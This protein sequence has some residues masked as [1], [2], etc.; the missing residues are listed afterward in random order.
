MP[1]VI[2]LLGAPRVERDD[3]EM[4]T[5]RGHKAWGLL[6]YLLLADAPV[7]RSTLCSLLFAD[8]DDPLAALRWNLSALR[9]LL[10]DASSFRGDPLTVR[11]RA[12]DTA[13]ACEVLRGSWRAL[14]ALGGFEHDLL[15]G[16]S[17]SSAPSFEIWLE[18]ERRRLRG[19]AEAQLHEAA[20][21]HLG[22]GDA[23]RAADLASRLVRLNPYDENYQALLV[24]ALSSAG[25]GVAAARQV[26]ACRDLFRRELGVEPGPALAA[27]AATPTAQPVRPAT[28]GRAGVI[29]QVEAGVAAI[30]AGAV[31]PGLHCL[32]LA[33]A[34]AE[35]LADRQLHVRALAALGTA[36][37]HA[38][39]GWDEEGATVLHRALAVAGAHVPELTAEVS[40]EL[41][42]VEFLRARYDRVEPWLARAEAEAGQDANL[43][44]RVLTVRGS[45]LTDVGRYGAA[46]EALHAALELLSD[47]RHRSYALSM[48]GRLHLLRRELDQAGEALD[49]SLELAGRRGWTAFVPWPESM[50]A[51]VDME[52]GDLEVAADRLDHAFA[53]SCHVGDPCWEGMA[54][55]GLGLLQWT[56]GEVEGALVTLR[57]ARARCTRL[58]DGYLWLDAYT[59][60][61]MCAIAV[62]HGLEEGRAWARELGA[63]AA[64]TGMRELAA[65]SFLH[66]AALGEPELLAAAA[67]LVKELDSPRLTQALMRADAQLVGPAAPV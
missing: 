26:A 5:P 59:L 18:T 62:D 67:V 9:K 42:F 48:L 8:A 54:G 12:G 7:P 29:A 15:A 14:E 45:A 64:R 35:E 37:V 66:R 63:I 23:G 43:R 53:L 2:H 24:R 36:L 55:R 51:A 56:R 17:F 57:D 50:R 40:R 44:G 47:D 33:V 13:D 16:M 11:L 19:A 60:E 52:R 46:R 4:P 30:G 38:V 25:E 20:R 27:A 28:R 61:A 39:R 65:W 6:A 31:E 22:A 49:R 58:P 41:G 34:E 3:R 1:L 32:R 21:T 10:G